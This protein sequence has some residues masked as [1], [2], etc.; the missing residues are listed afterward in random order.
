MPILPKYKLLMQSNL[1]QLSKDDKAKRLAAIII[2]FVS[3]FAF[4]L[5]LLFF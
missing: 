2:V 5:K 1:S 4:F 3:V